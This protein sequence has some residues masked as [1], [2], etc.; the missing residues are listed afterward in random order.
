MWDGI[1]IVISN[2]KITLNCDPL[3][4]SVLIVGDHRCEP[5]SLDGQK[6]VCTVQTPGSQ[7]HHEASG[8]RQARL[9]NILLPESA[10]L[11]VPFVD[12]ANAPIFPMRKHKSWDG[13][14]YRGKKGRRSPCSTKTVIGSITYA[15]GKLSTGIKLFISGK[16]IEVDARVANI[17]VA[18]PGRPP[19]IL[20]HLTCLRPS[21]TRP[22]PSEFMPPMTVPACSINT[23]PTRFPP[24]NPVQPTHS[25]DLLRSGNRGKFDFQ[26]KGCSLLSKRLY[27]GMIQR[28]RDYSRVVDPVIWEDSAASS[29]GRGHFHMREHDGD[30]VAGAY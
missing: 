17:P 12:A 6:L 16:E 18:G 23:V 29:T 1:C 28:Q 21:Q 25:M 4:D 8:L 7:S 14:G 30:E 11:N 10:G 3:G 22:P 2:S 19:S 24:I 9:P 13:D 20:L 5:Q 27:V 15:S 26:V